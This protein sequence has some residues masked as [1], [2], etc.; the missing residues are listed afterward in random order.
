M[1]PVAVGAVWAGSPWFGIL[2]FVF[3]A[4]MLWEWLRMC[5]PD[6]AM[7]LAGVAS[8]GLAVAMYLLSVSPQLTVFVPVLVAALVVVVASGKQ[9]PL[10]MAGALYI[11][12]AALAAQWLRAWH[13][14]GLLLIMW[15]FFVVWATDTGAYAFGRAIGGPKLAP[16]FSPKK[17]WA[18]LIGGMLCAALIGALIVNFS[19]GKAIW[20][21]SL[22]SAALAIIAQIGDLA[23]SGLKRRFGV[24][25]SSNLI[26]GHGGFLDRADGMLSVFPVAFVI[27]YFFDLA[28]R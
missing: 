20:A 12:V 15:L 14:D 28:L 19:G 13:P 25:D 6:R 2:L 22:A 3:S 21:I 9:R 11:P 18:G 26:P 16:Q 10:V 1:T 7:V 17:T 23:E 27:I 8:A 4:A 24:K 5:V